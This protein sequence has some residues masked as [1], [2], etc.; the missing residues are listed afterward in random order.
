MRE[1]SIDEGLRGFGRYERVVKHGA[2]Q[3]KVIT[4]EDG[5]REERPVLRYTGLRL[6]D[7]R[8]CHGQWATDEGAP[9][10]KVQAALRHASPGMTRRYTMQKDRGEVARMVGRALS[11]RR[12]G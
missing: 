8:H 12:T 1:R 10:S 11:S 5:S 9:E 2:P 6:Q 3:V 4:H 7:L